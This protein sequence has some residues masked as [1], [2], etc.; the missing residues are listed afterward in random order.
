[1]RRCTTVVEAHLRRKHVQMRGDLFAFL[2]GTFYRWA[3]LWPEACP[4]LR[5]AP[6][7]LAIGDLHV[8]SFGTWRDAEGRLC[9]GV[10]DFDDA[11]PLAYTN[12][13]VRL[14]ASAR[15][16]I[17]D[18]RLAMSFRDACDAILEGY[19]G[20]LRQGGCPI[21]L[22]EREVTLERLG[23]AALKPPEDF[24]P[25]LQALP[26]VRRPLRSDARRALEH[27]LPEPG[28]KY[29]V[30]TRTTGMGSLGQQRFAA[31]AMWK[32]GLVAREVKSMVPSALAWLD[33]RVNRDESYYERALDGAVRSRDPFQSITGAWLVRRLSPDAN[34][35]EI[36]D[37]P[38]KRDEAVLLQSMGI[39]A[40][41]VHLGSRRQTRRILADL[42]RRKA[43]WLRAAARAMA[44]VVHDEWKTFRKAAG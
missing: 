22:G 7:V 6:R 31:I 34:P 3:E 16:V 37:L 23:I 43:N 40:A 15:I 35:I 30:V 42:Q 4:D 21:V 13:L 14:A 18:D 41:N 27:A 17:D 10:D 29:S 2:R 20:T 19:R 44:D 5:D 8:D 32:G 1:M 26:H 36:I 11:Y 38:K 24:W 9:W 25:K 12:D 39:E 33:G 28:L